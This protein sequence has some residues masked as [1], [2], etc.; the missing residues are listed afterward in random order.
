MLIG[1]AP[2]A[3]EDV[4]GLPFVGPAGEKHGAIK[5]HQILVGKLGI[6]LRVELPP[7]EAAS[8]VSRY[9]A[10]VD[11]RTSSPLSVRRTR[12]EPSRLIW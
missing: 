8:A 12:L 2:G 11:R 3:E 9:D 1:E 5:G 6:E 10:I 4:Q 7:D